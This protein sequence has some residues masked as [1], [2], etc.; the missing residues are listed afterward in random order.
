MFLTAQQRRRQERGAQRDGNA[1]A[2]G[3]DAIFRTHF[4]MG[5]ATGPLSEARLHE[6]LEGWGDILP[7]GRRLSAGQQVADRLFLE[8]ELIH[9]GLT[10]RLRIGCLRKGPPL[11]HQ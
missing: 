9:P 6:F 5:D 2:T 1:V 8:H 10:S 11:P 7:E 4:G 3:A